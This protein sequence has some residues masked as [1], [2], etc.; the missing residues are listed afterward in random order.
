MPSTI[1][2]PLFVLYGSVTGN[3][4]HI[5]KDLAAKFESSSS[6][7]SSPFDG[8]ICCD[9][10]KFKKKC[11]SYWDTECAVGSKY[12]VLIV[13]STTGNGDAPENAG[14][15][16]R[17]IKK[18][19]TVHEQPFRHCV[20]AVLGLGDTNY[21]QFCNTGKILDKKL[22]ELGGTRCRKLECADEATGLEEVVESWTETILVEIAT[23]CS[24]QKNNDRIIS[25]SMD[26]GASDPAAEE[27]NDM[28]KTT[29]SP[30]PTTESDG[31]RLVRALLQIG[32]GESIMNV[33]QKKLPALLSSRSSCELVED[34]EGGR[35]R[36][37]S[38][39]DDS[40]ASS[41]TFHYSASNPFESTIL[42]A[43]YL[44]N[45]STTAAKQAALLDLSTVE[46]LQAA[47]EIFDHAFD[48]SDPLNGK[49]VIEL[50]LSLPD[51]S[52]LHY[53]PGDSLGL[54]VENTPETVQF[55]LDMLSK[56]HGI[57]PTQLCKIDE[58]HPM[59]VADAIRSELD[60]SSTIKSKRLLYAFSQIAADPQ[61]ASCLRLLSSKTEIGDQLFEQIVNQQRLNVV[62][63]LQLF[64]STQSVTLQGL[65]GIV[66][67]IP[68]RYYSVSSSPIATKKLSLT[69]AFS[70]VDYA[71][72]SL[73][74]EEKE[75][76]FRRIR[77]IATRYLEVLSSSLLSGATKPDES[78]SLRIFPKP[79]VDFRMP[80]SRSTPLIL[81]GPGTGIAPFM[82]FLQ[83][84]QA[85]G[86]EL[87]GDTE[88]ARKGDQESGSIDVF[89]GCR[90]RDHDYLYKVELQEA[91]E[92]GVLNNLYTAFSRDPGSE[93]KY[94]QDIMVA[95]EQ[96]AVRLSNLITK[97]NAAIFICG[98]GNAMAKDV[99]GAI[100][101]L[102]SSRCFDNNIDK[103]T[104]YLET[105]KKD[106]RLL[107]DIWS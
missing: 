18:K 14:R 99:Q 105:M 85:E 13:C 79:S 41:S 32:A 73:T 31:V 100:V 2:N 21:D 26:P 33:D 84:R 58:N 80:S 10:D 81:I 76:G 54:L 90:K 68:P 23:A 77:G 91:V 75:F 48:L 38:T 72:P 29:P 107:L 42:K 94:V 39:G 78:L 96:C 82:G 101:N 93:R 25:E 56:R 1:R 37:D 5:A 49:R 63:L 59:T 66:P 64:P 71:T 53:E 20:Y 57:A 98:D 47:L 35:H 36:A 16:V 27:V 4:E 102:L 19:D 69:V 45:T 103:A 6:S 74:I 104:N 55:V 106:K 12:G 28:E 44:T 9:L 51:D 43:R 92:K 50:T 62:D 61:E 97:N 24:N 88:I 67:A 30:T 89:F 60:L 22:H 8:V 17:Y 15:F 95:D 86:E 87:A 83:H 70:V 46:N 34:E 65:L 7:M 52:T 3:A 40:S 11:A